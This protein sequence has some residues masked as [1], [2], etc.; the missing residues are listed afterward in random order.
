MGIEDPLVLLF[1]LDLR[2]RIFQRDGAVE[3]EPSLRR[4]SFGLTREL[5]GPEQVVHDPFPQTR[6]ANR[7]WRSLREADGLCDGMH[8]EPGR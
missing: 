8:G 3:D 6:G 5:T 2:P 7:V 4:L 1:V